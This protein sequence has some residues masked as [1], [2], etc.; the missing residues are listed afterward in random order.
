MYMTNSNDMNTSIFTEY[1]VFVQDHFQS[2]LTNYDIQQQRITSQNTTVTIN[3]SENT[4]CYK[5]ID[6]KH[7]ITK[8]GCI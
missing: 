7:L 5:I 1:E 4:Q 3:I 8:S 6:W 2:L